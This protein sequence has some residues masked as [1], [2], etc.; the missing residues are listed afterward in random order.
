MLCKENYLEKNHF[1]IFIQF[2]K[3]HN[4]FACVVVRVPVLQPHRGGANTKVALQD[5]SV[6]TDI[7][8]LVQFV[9]CT[10]YIMYLQTV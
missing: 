9:V 3:F 4:I 2:G 8:I 5:T 6:K 10:D 7:R 1:Y